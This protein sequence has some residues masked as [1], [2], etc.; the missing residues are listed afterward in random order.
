MDSVFHLQILHVLLLLVDLNDFATNKLVPDAPTAPTSNKNLGFVVPIPTLETVLIPAS[1]NN[2]T[3]LGP[4]PLISKV[5]MK[6]D[7]V[8]KLANC[9][10]VGVSYR[11]G[12]TAGC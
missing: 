6:Y 2:S 12:G 9:P 4:I 1:T 8:F 5:L 11:S 7:I 3:V 10:A